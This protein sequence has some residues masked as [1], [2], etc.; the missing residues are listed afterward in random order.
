MQSSTNDPTVQ[1][2]VAYLLG[3]TYEYNDDPSTPLD[4]AKLQAIFSSRLDQFNSLLA[5]LRDSPAVKNA[6]QYLQISAADESISNT[7]HSLPSLLLDSVFVDL[8]KSTYGKLKGIKIEESQHLI[9]LL[10]R[11]YSKVNQKETY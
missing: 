6:P 10:C 5:R 2:L 7:T 1:G 11:K 3:I 8:F 4:R 9:E